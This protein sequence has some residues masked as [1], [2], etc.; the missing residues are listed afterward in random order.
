MTDVAFTV[1]LSLA[2]PGVLTLAAA[3]GIGLGNA[4][5]RTAPHKTLFNVGQDVVAITA[6]LGAFHLVG[7]SGPTDPAAWLGATL[8]MGAYFAVNEVSLAGIISLVEGT[9]FLSVLTMPIALS[10]MQ[11]VGNLAI[12]IMGAALWRLSPRLLPLLAAP[13]VLAFVAYRAWLQSMGDRDRMRNLYEAGR[14]LSGPLQTNADFRRFLP[15]AIRMLGAAIVIGGWT[16]IFA[17]EIQE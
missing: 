2:R 16:G 13:L 14:A 17:V 12:G 15:L 4:I 1:G 5:R 7:R 6:A 3:S 9:S 11:F 8:A 10:L